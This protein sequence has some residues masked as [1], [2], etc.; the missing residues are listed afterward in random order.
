MMDEDEEVTC[1]DDNVITLIM[2]SLHL[3]PH[4]PGS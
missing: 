1:N 4:P 3:L 2:L